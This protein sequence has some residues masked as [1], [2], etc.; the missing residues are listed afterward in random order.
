MR[1]KE[2]I[3]F[4]KNL[5]GMVLKGSMLNALRKQTFATANN[6]IRYKRRFPFLFIFIFHNIY[7]KKEEDSRERQKK[8]CQQLKCLNQL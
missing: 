8:L 6:T 5:L 7:M 3:P 1:V 2:A 4:Q